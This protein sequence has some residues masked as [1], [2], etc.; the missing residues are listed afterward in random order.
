LTYR[1]EQVIEAYYLLA[2]TDWAAFTLDYQFIVNPGYN[3]ARGPVSIGAA[4]MHVQF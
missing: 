3:A 2:L 1:P 4:R